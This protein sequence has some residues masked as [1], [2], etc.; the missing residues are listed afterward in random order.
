MK[1]KTYDRI[2][3]MAEKVF[4]SVQNKSTSVMS[5]ELEIDDLI[6]LVMGEAGG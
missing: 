3:R 1:T 6:V 2:E 5:G 4:T